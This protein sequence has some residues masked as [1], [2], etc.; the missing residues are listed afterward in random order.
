MNN[1]FL[2]FIIFLLQA[3]CS[4]FTQEI[5]TKF[6]A[7][8]KSDFSPELLKQ[9]PNANAI[10]LMNKGYFEYETF[11]TRVEAI[12]DI[13]IRI[14][15]LNKSG[16][17]YAN[18]K[19][20]Y[21]GL[22]RIERV[23]GIKGA[24]YTLENGKIVTHKLKSKDIYFE[25]IGEEWESRNFALPQVCEGC[26][27][28]YR[29]KLF[30]RY[31]DNLRTFYFQ[32]DV[33]V[34]YN[35]LTT[36]IPQ[37]YKYNSVLK[38][39]E[40]LDSKNERSYSDTFIISGR[41]GAGTHEFTGY[42]TVYVM[43]NVAPLK[44]EPLISSRNN[45][46]SRILF[47]LY[48]VYLP[49][50][51]NLTFVEDWDQMVTY[52][53]DHKYLGDKLKFNVTLR[54]TARELTEKL[55]DPLDKMIVIYNYVKDNYKWNG[56][57]RKFSFYALSRVNKDK[58]GNSATINIVLTN[59]LR[60]AGLNSKAAILSTRK[61][62]M[63]NMSCPLMVDFDKLINCT[64]IDNEIFLLDATD[65]YRPYN[66]LD[67]NT[68]NHDALILEKNKLDWI[69]LKNKINT[70]RIISGNLHFD[71]NLN[72]IV[73]IDLSDEG[74]FAFDNRKEIIINGKDQFL[75]DEYRKKLTDIRIDTF[76]IDNLEEY[77]HKLQSHISFTTSSFINK[78]EN[79]IFI[80]PLL[81][82]ALQE[83]PFTTEG[84]IYPINF[85]YPKEYTYIINITVPEGYEITKLP[86]SI[87]LVL[88]D[89]GA[90][91]LYQY[92]TA[93]SN[94]QLMCKIKF[95]KTE[96]LAIEYDHLKNLFENMI[97]KQRESI[98][99]TKLE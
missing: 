87:K 62:G 3:S 94:I 45:F 26:I 59:M 38:G 51:V 19:I 39:Y 22:E 72:L 41:Y 82:F 71:E 74:Y 49:G 37:F 65:H 98:V 28:E 79:Q 48:Q 29:Y 88:P 57:N 97:S 91:F 86:E 50:I 43:K 77:N 70:K 55:E 4:A 44:K 60:E 9:Y 85:N 96:Y 15:I 76:Y 11:G 84:R 54:K 47:Q 78:S 5:N 90:E 34:V 42:E 2:L 10:L 8:S 27:I 20:P 75:D 95:S 32:W 56:I 83:S 33:P 36:R 92:T 23:E 30:S 16:Y 14:L 52:L 24:T 18:V 73:K 67:K 6:G 53:L 81:H 12:Y 63:I 89:K 80:Q 61:N 58:Q 64:K 99:L 7:V 66:L 17:N 69:P 1:T 46:T 40:I 25:E 21:F 13:H 31:F 35:E 93:G 68:L